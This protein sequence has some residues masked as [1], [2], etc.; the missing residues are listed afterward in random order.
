MKTETKQRVRKKPCPYCQKKL[1][2]TSKTKWRV[3]LARH[4]ANTCQAYQCKQI[5]I[6]TRMMWS[7]VE[8]FAPDL[9]DDL[10]REL[11]AELAQRQHAQAEISELERIAKL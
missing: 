8:C 3:N 10:R 6:A 11:H 9:F 7:M 2:H 1:K 4:L 5:E